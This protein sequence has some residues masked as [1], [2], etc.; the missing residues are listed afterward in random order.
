MTKKERAYYNERYRQKA[1]S[2]ERTCNQCG[3]I[4]SK[5]RGHNSYCSDECLKTHKR[6][7][8]KPPTPEKQ[9]EYSRRYTDGHRKEVYERTK[10]WRKRNPKH[11]R[12][13]QR[14]YQQQWRKDN[15]D[16]MKAILDRHLKKKKMINRLQGKVT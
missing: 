7:N 9:R 16:K 15:P 3:T 14:E 11:Y 10:S 1:L 13:Y 2:I 12:D 4:F 5:H 8:K 6:E